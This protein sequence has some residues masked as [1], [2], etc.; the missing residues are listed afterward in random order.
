[1]KIRTRLSLAALLVVTA[2]SLSTLSSA[3]AQD[4][5][6]ATQ[7]RDQ[8]V[9]VLSKTGSTMR[10]GFEAM[11]QKQRD[12]AAVDRALAPRPAPSPRP[13]PTPTGSARRIN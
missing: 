6:T 11:R 8:A 13:S 12:D 10:D 7:R 1:M 9:D 4:T 2:A 3:Q 5:D